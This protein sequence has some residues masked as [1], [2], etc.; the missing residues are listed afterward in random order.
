MRT[1]SHEARERPAASRRPLASPPRTGHRSSGSMSIKE[2][3]AADPHRHLAAAL[4]DPPLDRAERRQRRAPRQPP[5]GPGLLPAN[6]GFGLISACIVRAPQRLPTGKEDKGV[7]SALG[8][9]LGIDE[10]ARRALG[11]GVV[12]GGCRLG[13]LFEGEDVAGSGGRGHGRLQSG[14]GEVHSGRASIAPPRL[15]ETTR[16]PPNPSRAPPHGDEGCIREGRR[17]FRHERRPEGSHQALLWAGP[18]ILRR[19]PKRVD[20]GTNSRRS[21]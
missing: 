15:S 11:G 2:A 16:L 7:E 19:A 13:T 18:S 3:P 9:R 10:E 1:V 6:N 20:P 5:A 17:A 21:S 4:P 12:P 14:I 8:N